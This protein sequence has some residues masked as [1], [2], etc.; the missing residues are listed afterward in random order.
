MSASD[1][2]PYDTPPSLRSFEAGESARRARAIEAMAKAYP[3]SATD[4]FGAKRFEQSR[5]KTP[6]GYK[7]LFDKV[8]RELIGV[9]LTRQQRRELRAQRQKLRPEQ[10]DKNAYR[11]PLTRERAPRDMPKRRS[12]GWLACNFILPR[13]TVEG[14]TF[15]AR[16]MADRER[17]ERLDEP[18]GVRRRYPKTKN[19]YVTE[20]LNSLLADHG[21]SQFCVP[22]AEPAAG[23]V[24]RFVVPTD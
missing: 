10:I 3:I 16:S 20:A 12:P 14:L 24:R 19:F 15:L 7:R 4:P 1:S 22:E 13:M 8:S 9:P 5:A 11:H 17:A 2:F 21:L 6:Y 23:R 18:R